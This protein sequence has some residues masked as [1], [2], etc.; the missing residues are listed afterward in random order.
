MKRFI[1]ALAVSLTLTSQSY[2]SA[3]P[4]DNYL[5]LLK[6]NVKGL[7]S[8]GNAAKGEIE[9]I[10]DPAIMSKIESTTGRKVG[11]VH[12][13]TYW[14][15]LNDAVKFPNG[16]TGV[17]GRLVWINALQGPAGVAV[18]PVLS[19]GKIVLNRNY[20]HATR[21]WE[22]EL[23]RGTSA[24]GEQPEVTALREA[25]EETG[26]DLTDITL[27]GTMAPDTGMTSS[28]VPVYMAQVT[29]TGIATPEDSE[30]IAGI[31]AFSVEELKEGLKRGY[32]NGIPLRDPFLA[33]ALL[34]SGL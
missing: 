23:P 30:A 29:S 31:E 8:A 18:M 27:L 2:A 12:R 6:E 15:W 19:N 16:K 17:Y 32:L 20:R 24:K 3:G 14:I 21:S 13:D 4:Y 26:M 34:N 1:S 11:I 5:L 7:G 28:L 10:L 9:I 33:Y 25:K 22:Y